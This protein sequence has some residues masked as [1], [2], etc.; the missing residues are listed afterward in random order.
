ME[1]GATLCDRPS[2]PLAEQWGVVARKYLHLAAS[3]FGIVMY[4][5]SDGFDTDHFYQSARSGCDG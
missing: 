4:L 5:T 3:I 2:G 1:S